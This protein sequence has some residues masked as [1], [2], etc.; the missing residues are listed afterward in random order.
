MRRNN[1]PADARRR[2]NHRA[3]TAAVEFG[4]LALPLLAVLLLVFELSYDLFTQTV[5]D[6]ALQQAA[7]RVQT[8][9][10][11]NL[12]GSSFISG[13]MCPELEGLLSCA[14]VYVSV[15]RITPGATQDYYDFTTGA[16]PMA[17]GQLDLSAYSGGSFC[18]SGPSQLLLVSAIYVGPAFLGSLLSNGFGVP[19][20]GQ[21][22][23]ATLSTVGIVSEGYSPA[24]A[25]AGS[26]PSC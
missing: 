16:P 15:Q 1:R 11:Q 20:Q 5:L 13:I 23:H 8:G 12:T 26:A 25:P 3:G 2:K 22:V 10:A 7:R 21:T 18:N 17:G 19:Y 6:G 4:I 9:N 24:A 14:N